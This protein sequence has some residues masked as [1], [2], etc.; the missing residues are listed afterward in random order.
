VH[1]KFFG[2]SDKFNEWVPLTR[3]APPTSMLQRDWLRED[4]VVVFAPEASTENYET[5]R[6]ARVLELRS[7]RE[8]ALEVR[9]RVDTS[10]PFSFNSPKGRP[11]PT[12]EEL[13]EEGIWLPITSGKIIE[14][15]SF[16][17]ID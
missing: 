1:V 10:I 15:G 14:S 12:V 8:H 5:L 9:I 4:S 7:S 16:N 3:V 2:W 6:M 11:V 13:S 17:T